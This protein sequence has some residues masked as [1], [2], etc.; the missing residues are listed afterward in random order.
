MSKFVVDNAGINEMLYLNPR[1]AAEANKVGRAAVAS[2]KSLVQAGGTKEAQAVANAVVL[3][4]AEVKRS[5]WLAGQIKSKVGKAGSGEFYVA[6]V[7]SNH[8]TTQFWEF[9]TSKRKA[10]HFMRAALMQTAEKFP[11]VRKG[12][13]PKKGSAYAPKGKKR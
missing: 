4:P 8:P 11:Y 3:R 12:K 6:V 2:A 5:T 9:G 1:I 7:A 10:T 13:Q